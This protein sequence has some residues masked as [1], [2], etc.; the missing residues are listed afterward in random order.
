MFMMIDGWY[1]HRTFCRVFVHTSARDSLPRI[2][3]LGYGIPTVVVTVS[4]GVAWDQYGSE[5]NCWLSSEGA[6]RCVAFP[7]CYALQLRLGRNNCKNYNH[8]LLTLYLKIIMH[9]TSNTA[10]VVQLR[11]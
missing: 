11:V 6:L 10:E 4:V 2:A 7:R 3:T 8:K 1:L 9:N 5:E